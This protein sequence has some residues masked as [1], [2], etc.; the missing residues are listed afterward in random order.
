MDL[1]TNLTLG[2]DERWTTEINDIESETGQNPNC[3]T[4]PLDPFGLD[5]PSIVQ[6]LNGCSVF[7]S[8]I[9]RESEVVLLHL[10]QALNM[11]PD[12]H[13]ISPNIRKS[14]NFLTRHVKFLIISRRNFV[15][16]TPKSAAA[17]SNPISLR[18]FP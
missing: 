2:D 14:S 11:I 15:L 12:L 3:A 4:K 16:E 18:M 6:R 10:E 9:E 1:E 17:K 5:L 8:L 13:S 7:L